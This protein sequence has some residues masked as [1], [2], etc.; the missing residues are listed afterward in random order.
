MRFVEFTAKRK[1]FLSSF[2]LVLLTVDL[3]VFM[4]LRG[5]FP[6]VYGGMLDN[7]LSF[8]SAL[9]F[10]TTKGTVEASLIL[11]GFVTATISSCMLLMIGSKEL[12]TKA[13]S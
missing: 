12:R 8:F 4:I 13:K 1:L 6:T 2:F 10:I 5:D 3:L 7:I 11:I 9:G